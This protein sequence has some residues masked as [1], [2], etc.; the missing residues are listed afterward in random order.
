VKRFS[1]LLIFTAVLIAGCEKAGSPD[2]GAKVPDY[3]ALQQAAER[4]VPAAGVFGGEMTL[5]MLSEPVS[6][7]PIITA[8]PATLELLSRQYEGLVRINPVTLKAEP[9]LAK[10]WE[11]SADGLIWTFQIRDGVQ[12]S[13]GAAFSAYDVE[14]TFNELIFNDSI[15]PVPSRDL[16]TIHGKRPTV[17]AVDSGTVRFTLTAP[18]APFLRL[19]TQEILPKHKYS[20]SVRRG[21]FAGALGIQTP[22]DS[23]TGTGPFLLDLFVSSQKAVFKR[24]PL[25]WQKDG[26]G[27]R[28][29]YLD[30]LAYFFIADR[31]AEKSLMLRGGLD[32]FMTTGEDMAEVQ[33]NNDKA[34]FSVF[35]CG[36]AS[37]STVL[38]FNQNTGRDPKTGNPYVDPVKLAWFRNDAFRKAVALAL[39]RQSMIDSVFGGR[40]YCQWSPMSPSEGS[41]F[42]TE[43][44]RYDY[45]TVKARELLSQAGFKD[46][47]NDGI[48]ED[49]AGRPVKFTFITNHGN[50]NREKIAAMI[51]KNLEGLGF[52]IQ[53][54]PLVFGDMVNRIDK[55]P[56]SWDAAL[57]G[58]S[59]GPDPSFSEA[60]WLS[61]GDRH[62]WFPVQKTPSTAWEAAIDSA[63]LAARSELDDAKRRALYAGWQRI[64]ADRLPLIYTV[65]PERI[66]C[67]SRKFRNVN[68]SMTGGVLHNLE[69]IFTDTANQRRCDKR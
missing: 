50:G 49:S 43:V 12:W 24:N 34:P 1:F 2:A 31:D 11:A 9:C 45:D 22:P 10:S 55:S 65:V 46:V 52:R 41:Y 29:P 48:L 13:D 35:S 26:A 61:G 58:L 5:S 40:G 62:M 53:F 47:N 3:V 15:N 17:K 20:I 28:L 54:Q 30:R 66:I 19:M 21:P 60:L 42:C 8:D 56:Y 16:F 27:K 32:C 68:P 6:F 64:A 69:W 59:G 67:V 63:F 14:F 25:Y 44:N 36:P 23:M 33:K 38:L 57:I 37:G 4:F 18:F 51:M 7:N 39:D